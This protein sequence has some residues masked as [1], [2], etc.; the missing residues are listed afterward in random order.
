[1]TDLMITRELESYRSKTLTI[2]ALFY[3]KN[4]FETFSA[5]LLRLRNARFTSLF[6]M[7]ERNKIYQRKTLNFTETIGK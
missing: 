2:F 3:R 1:M 4:F 5:V 7:G 6:K